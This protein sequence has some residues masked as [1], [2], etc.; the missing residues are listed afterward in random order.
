MAG[1]TNL[2]SAEAIKERVEKIAKDINRDF[3]GEDLVHIVITLNGAFMFAADLVRL[4]DIPQQISFASV[5]SY[6]GTQQGDLSLNMDSLPRSFGNKP[7]VVIEDIMDTGNTVA[8]LRQVMADRMASTIKI[9]ALLK[10][11]DCKGHADY[12]G[13]TVPRSLFVIGY[14]MDMDSRYRELSGI[15]V[16][17]GATMSGGGGLC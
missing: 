13:F 7:V 4:L 6:S 8:A 11:Q 1:M 3:K 9:V 10:R 12:F 14:G 5:S 2:Y 15:K 16:L 17:D